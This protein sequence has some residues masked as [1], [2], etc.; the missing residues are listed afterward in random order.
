[1]R[2]A[3]VVLHLSL[4]SHT[5][6]GKTTLARTLL[7]RD[8]G[9]V[10]DE[11]HVT[12][13]A[14]EFELIST[15]AG[16]SLRLW[17]TPGF[18]DTARLLKRLRQLG[19]PIGWLLSQVWDRYTDRPFWSTQQAIRNVREHADVILYLVNAGEDP[20]TAGYVDVEM[21]I[22]AW[23][24]KPI[25]LL[26]NQV[27]APRSQEQDAAELDRWRNHVQQYPLVRA[28]LV[29]DA[30]ARCWV[31]EHVL[32]ETVEQLLPAAARSGSRRLRRAW[33]HRNLDIF[34]RSLNVL[35]TQIAATAADR[36]TVPTRSLK[37]RARAWLGQV[38]I[39]AER[40]DPA[41]ERAMTLLAGRLDVRVRDATQSLI[42]LHGL[43]GQATREILTRLGG[44]FS[45]EQP[46]DAGKATVIGALVSGAMGGL[47]A[48]LAA[49]GLTFGAG[50]LIGGVLG[51]LGAGGLTTAYNVARGTETSLVRWSPGFLS[52]RVTAAIIRYL[53]VAH[54]GRG[55]GEFV[56]GEFPPF[57]G[58]MV[59]AAV[60]V[61]RDALYRIW[62]R[63]QDG[64]PVADAAGLLEPVLRSLT[65][66]VLTRLY[67]QAAAI[68]EEAEAGA[69]A[70]SRHRAS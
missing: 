5:N 13:L 14:E 15:T 50:A 69:E 16:D 26:L 52:D 49:S 33:K 64:A 7:R 62:Q 22:L 66:K 57:W 67:P 44:E 55:R 47:A 35:A 39:G 17:D 9:E 27:G 63:L 23:I 60:A 4:I 24:G 59:T 34:A 29:L 54:F 8:I 61:E 12:E 2:D 53:A 20:A 43:S 19:N 68:F 56:T 6:V 10:R 32:L 31:Q 70:A 3:P 36:E 46:V 28:V 51:A 1:M 25:V 48:D 38:A 30:F 65:G 45:V 37:E 41:L 40:G 58:E 11:A 18:G 42:E 21:Q